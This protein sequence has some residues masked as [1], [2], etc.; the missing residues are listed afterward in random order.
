MIKQDLRH[1]PNQ[2]NFQYRCCLFER[3][4]IFLMNYSV[5]K[6]VSLKL[7]CFSQL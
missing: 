6:T 5:F 2:I 1:F 7:M 4:K 3:F